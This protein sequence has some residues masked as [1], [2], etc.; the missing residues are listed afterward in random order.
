MSFD[1][2][3]LYFFY[4]AIRLHQELMNPANIHNF[5]SVDRLML[6]LVHE[7]AQ[8]RDVYMTEELTKHL[9]QTP[10]IVCYK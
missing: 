8:T 10:G 9:F 6:G 3:R 1:S 7:A 5:G 4:T 2:N